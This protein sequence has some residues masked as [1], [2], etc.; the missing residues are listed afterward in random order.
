MTTIR[1]PSIV[2]PPAPKEYD[3]KEQNEFRRILMNALAESVEGVEVAY[4]LS[5]GACEASNNGAAPPP[6]NRLVIPI[7]HANLPSGTTFDVSYNNGV[8]G[9][10][11][12]RTDITL[13]ASPQNVTFN[14]VTF[15]GT[16]GSGAVTVIAKLNGATVVTAVRNKT[17]V[18]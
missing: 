6:Y 9:G 10:M 12:S 1:R 17:Y 3:Q 11:D 4:Q 18:T 14:S 5:I 13:A 15:A 16:P 7:T 8:A 2:L